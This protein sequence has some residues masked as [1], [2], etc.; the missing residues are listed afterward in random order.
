[1]ITNQREDIAFFIHAEKVIEER[2]QSNVNQTKVEALL[3]K[4]EEKKP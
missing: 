3:Q 4:K 1:M 2:K